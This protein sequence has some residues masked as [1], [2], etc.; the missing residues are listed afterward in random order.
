[1]VGLELTTP[2]S[3]D[4]A[5]QMPPHSLIIRRKNKKGQST[6]NEKWKVILCSKHI[7]KTL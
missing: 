7:C 4:C 2:R 6:L 1:M 5:S 3:T